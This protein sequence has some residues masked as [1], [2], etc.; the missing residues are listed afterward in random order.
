MKLF[1]QVDPGSLDRRMW[2]LWV[3]ALTTILVLASGLAIMMYAV[4]FSRPAGPS[5]HMFIT[6]FAG[7]CVLMPLV[8]GYL[9]DRQLVIKQLRRK[10]SEEEHQIVNLLH[11]VK[12][13]FLETLP[14]VA[15]FQ[16]RLSMEFRRAS[17]A[18]QPIS[19]VTVGVRP[20]H[21]ASGPSALA[22]ISGEAAKALMRKLRGEDSIYHFGGG[23]FSILLPRVQ[24]SI[25]NQIVDRLEEGLR[26]AAGPDYHFVFETHITNYPD[27][28]CSAREM[29]KAVAG[30][31]SGRTSEPQ[32]SHLG[33]ATLIAA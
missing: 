2:Q 20:S 4:F 14:G 23:V 3:L 15:H 7:Y 22:G 32:A 6:L 13:N 18:E 5:G 11:E 24:T 27:Q 21:G 33:V 12:T 26:D 29:E 28:V 9:L 10:I 30:F 25:A 1:D 8:L 16:D 31:I 17:R 19:M